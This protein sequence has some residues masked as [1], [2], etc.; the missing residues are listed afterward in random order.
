[1]GPRDL[2]APGHVQ[3]LLD[4]DVEDDEGLL[5]G[6]IAEEIEVRI[7]RSLNVAAVAMPVVVDDQTRAAE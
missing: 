2:R 1:M 7:R 4:G 3:Q 5:R 6:S